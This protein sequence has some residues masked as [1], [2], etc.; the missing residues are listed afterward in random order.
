MEGIYAA[1]STIVGNIDKVVSVVSTP[2]SDN[3]HWIQLYSSFLAPISRRIKGVGL[4]YGAVFRRQY[5]GEA[6]VSVYFTARRPP[7]LFTRRNTFF[8]IRY[9][10]SYYFI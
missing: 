3:L 8:F 5:L 9:L 7:T 6:E 1:D 4:S 2:V 10:L